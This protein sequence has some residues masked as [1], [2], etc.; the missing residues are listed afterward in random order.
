MQQS[1][2][3]VGSVEP[4]AF[5]VHRLVLHAFSGRR[6]PGDFQSYL[7]AMNS[8]HPG[9]LIHVVSVD[10][11]LDPTW[12]DVTSEACQQFWFRG[13]RERFVV[14]YL[15]GPPCETWS[16]AREH[17]LS[18]EP[19]EHGRPHHGPRVVR[20]LEAW[21]GLESL[22]EISQVLT[23]NHLLLF[24]F[25]MMVLLHASGGCGALEHPAPPAN[26]SSAS[27][28]RTDI[29]ML[30]QTLPGIQLV[31]LALGLLGA[32]APKHTAIMTLNLPDFVDQ[33]RCGRVCSE[34][35]VA[36][37]IGRDTSG[38]WRTSGLKEYLPAL[39]RIL[40]CSFSSAIAS[41]PP[42]DQALICKDFWATCKGMIV[43]QHGSHI[44][45]DWAG[46]R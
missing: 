42:D 13:V 10:I 3:L 29:A 19:G 6:R 34:L 23:G 32:N 18:C 37:S 35:P 27:I 21:W 33:V 8:T 26:P 4:R 43:T 36:S 15:A 12:G 44:G 5:G 40:A 16:V 41:C 1:S 46:H 31:E 30:L 39:C 9:V 25:R 24:S 11:L 45:P 28:W 14:G 17:Q 7:D 22:S 20:T 38:H 2:P